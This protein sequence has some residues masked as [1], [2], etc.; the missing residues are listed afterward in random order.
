MD[1]IILTLKLTG[2]VLLTGLFLFGW[3][4]LWRRPEYGFALAYAIGLAMC[5][6]FAGWFAPRDPPYIFSFGFSLAGQDGAARAWIGRPQ[7]HGILA[8]LAFFFPGAA[9]VAFRKRLQSDA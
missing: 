9:L 3:Y 4:K 2:P 7:A 6:V 8:A 1:V 5:F